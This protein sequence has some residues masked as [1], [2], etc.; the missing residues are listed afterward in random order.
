MVVL[1]LFHNLNCSRELDILGS[2]T[3]L[4]Y[5]IIG[6]CICSEGF[7][8]YQFHISIDHYQEVQIFQHTSEEQTFFEL[9][10]CHL[11]VFQLYRETNSS[12]PFN[13]IR[14][15]FVE[16]R[17]I[18]TKLYLSALLL[19]H[20]RL[21]QV[22]HSR[23]FILFYRFLHCTYL[24]LH[25]LYFYSLRSKK[26]QSKRCL[27]SV[28]RICLLSIFIVLGVI[29]SSHRLV[30]LRTERVAFNSL[31]F[32]PPTHI[33]M[34]L[35]STVLQTNHILENIFFFE[36]ELLLSWKRSNYVV[37]QV[38]SRRPFGLIHYSVQY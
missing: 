18:E 10:C 24:R 21:F 35:V 23:N 6:H 33:R 29:I 1:L 3:S 36:L 22:S 37:L 11:R 15:M 5:F 13:I 25:R 14:I 16:K 9:A 38:L 19:L 31:P 28:Q 2:C 4:K 8:V 7:A 34:Q 32:A 30:F 26:S 27:L 20:E 12:K 17:T